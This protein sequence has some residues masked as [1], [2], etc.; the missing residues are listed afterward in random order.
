MRASSRN[1]TIA[2]LVGKRENQ[3]LGEYIDLDGSC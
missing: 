2:D 1:T 3:T